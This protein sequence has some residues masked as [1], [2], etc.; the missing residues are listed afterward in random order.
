VLNRELGMTRR[1]TAVLVVLKANHRGQLAANFSTPPGG[2]IGRDAIG[3]V[4][5]LSAQL[6][7]PRAAGHASRRPAVH[8]PVS[9]SSESEGQLPA[10][11]NVACPLSPFFEDSYLSLNFV[12]GVLE[13]DEF[14]QGL[15]CFQ[16]STLL[17]V[18][19]TI[20]NARNLWPPRIC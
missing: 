16:P 7:Q 10:D 3:D 11:L 20:Q 1:G 18:S 2:P 17:D 14:E 6:G 12:D 8:E 9:A 13:R 5:Q 4:L 19:A 15:V